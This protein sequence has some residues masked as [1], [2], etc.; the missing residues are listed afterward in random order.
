MRNPLACQRVGSCSWLNNPRSVANVQRRVWCRRCWVDSFHS[1]PETVDTLLE[2]EWLRL[3]SKT[4]SAD[5]AFGRHL[6][7][8]L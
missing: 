2:A 4:V 7:T 3:R 6:W 8:S 5:A 1:H